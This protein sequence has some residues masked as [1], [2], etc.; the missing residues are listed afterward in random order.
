MNKSYIPKYNM[1]GMVGQGGLP[2]PP[3]MVPGAASAGL[4]PQGGA[5]APPQADAQALEM[6][7]NQFVSQHPEQVA[8]MR[9]AIM[10]E[11]QSGDM[12]M[13]ELNQL[14]Q[15][16]TVAAQNPQMYPYIRQHA[17]QQ[18]IATEQ[19]IP[20]QYDQGLVFA[21]M[22]AGRAAQQQTAGGQAGAPQ[23]MEKGGP[24]AGKGKKGGVIIEA[25]EGEYVIPKYVVAM[26]GKEFFDS[27]V[28]KY[29][30]DG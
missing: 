6:Q 2:E 12:D 14:V 11:V 29:K 15:L 18:G 3:G 27:L 8:Q 26:K 13:Q 20:E 28:E 22:L 24:V 9:D 1:G 7:V 4:A 23:S 5:A 19:D 10:A 21:L 17:V 25:H 30:Q 16:A